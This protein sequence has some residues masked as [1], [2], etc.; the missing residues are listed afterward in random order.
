MGLSPA[1]DHALEQDTLVLIA[2]YCECPKKN[3]ENTYH[4]RVGVNPSV[5]G[6]H[7]KQLSTSVNR[8]P[9]ACKLHW[10]S[11]LMRHPRFHYPKYTMTMTTRAECSISLQTKHR[12]V[13]PERDVT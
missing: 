7:S 3:T 9:Q 1:P 2:L 4:G 13:P 10:L 11:S 12:A 6:S 8:F 5:S